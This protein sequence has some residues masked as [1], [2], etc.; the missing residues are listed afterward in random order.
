MN[1]AD[2][3]KL[4]PELV[5]HLPMLARQREEA[6]EH[7]SGCPACAS[8]WAREEE[9]MAG[10][11]RLREE[12][13][14]LPSPAIE[15]RLATA[16][17]QQASAR[18]KPQLGKTRFFPLQSGSWRPSLFR[19]AAL[20][21]LALAAL[22][23]WNGKKDPMQ[24]PQSSRQTPT[25]AT[26]QQPT[27]ISP[28][29]LALNQ[30]P[31]PAAAGKRNPAASRAQGRTRSKPA[32]QAPTTPKTAT[33]SPPDIRESLTDFLVVTPIDETYPSE[34]RQAVRVKLPR[35]AMAR[36]GLPVNM[37]RWDEPVQADVVLNQQGMIQAV[38][39]VK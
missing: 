39:F 17:R 27:T 2:F 29:V 8:R 21:P 25:P 13:L 1:C 23:F 7:L 19:V 6:L 30:T 37:E 22:F 16:L 10:L 4:V 9:L 26:V 31:L 11:A 33:L 35:S 20:I 34:Y 14:P 3:Q 38:R 36:F 28:Q 18:A 12:S 32:G 24:E 15:E 5:R